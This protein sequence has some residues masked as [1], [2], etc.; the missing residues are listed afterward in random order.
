MHLD[1]VGSLIIL[2]LLPETRAIASARA[3]KFACAIYR[4]REIKVFSLSGLVLLYIFCKEKFFVEGFFI[5]DCIK[6]I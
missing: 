4:T 5:G 2:T 1:L 3:G 6:E